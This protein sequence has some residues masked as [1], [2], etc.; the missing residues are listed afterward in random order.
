MTDHSGKVRFAAGEDKNNDTKIFYRQKGEWYE[1]S[2]LK[3]GL[4]DFSPISL[5]DTPNSIYAA[6]R[7]NNETMGCIKLTLIPVSS[8]KSFKMTR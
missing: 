6:G 2:N 3:L 4:D 5:A 8:K 1:S 7:K